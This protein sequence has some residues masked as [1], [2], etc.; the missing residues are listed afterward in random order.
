M[1]E[2]I[3]RSILRS[4]KSGDDYSYN[5]GV[6]LPL[7]FSLEMDGISGL[8]PHSALTIPSNTLPKSYIIQSGIDKGKQKIA[9]IL[10]SIE[11]NFNNNKWTTKIAGQTLN[12]RFE[13]L[14][15]EEKKAIQD[16]E[17]NKNH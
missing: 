10:H 17:V 6:I 12:I 11:Q 2:F 3:Q 8:I 5:A 4:L 15:E 1:Y 13:P 16:A 14:T 9:F 7:D